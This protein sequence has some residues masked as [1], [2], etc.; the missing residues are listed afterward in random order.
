LHFVDFLGKTLLTC[1]AEPPSDDVTI[2]HVATGKFRYD[3]FLKS[4]ARYGR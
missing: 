2:R 3:R 1:G 4:W